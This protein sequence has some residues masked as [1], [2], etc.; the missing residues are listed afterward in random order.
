MKDRGRVIKLLELLTL[1]VIYHIT[2]S[3]NLFLYALTLSLY[4]IFLSCFSHIT[5]KEK[6]KKYNDDYSKYK[7]LKYVGLS[8]TIVSLIF[9]ILSIFISDIINTS[10]N[11]S[12]TFIPCLVMSISIIT[13]P[14][15]KILLEYLESYNRPKLSN[16]LLNSY[17]IIEYFLM[18]IISLIFIKFIELPIHISI[19]LLYVSKIISY[20]II[21]IFE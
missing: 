6:I 8:I 19:S 17:Y 10:L 4:N 5:I 16:S 21:S 14:L 1:I 3:N 15:I 11:V 20:I 13:E 9:V 18:I 7:I 2:K 12:N